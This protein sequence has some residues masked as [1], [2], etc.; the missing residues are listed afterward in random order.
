MLTN[1]SLIL[2][3]I[4]KYFHLKKKKKIVY[5]DGCTSN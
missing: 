1:M 4:K 2:N 3:F 5:E